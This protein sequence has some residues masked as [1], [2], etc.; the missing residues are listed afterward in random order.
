MRIKVEQ[1]VVSNDD[2]KVVA[3]KK[4]KLFK[5]STALKSKEVSIR[6]IMITSFNFLFRFRNSLFPPLNY[7]TA[8]AVTFLLLTQLLRPT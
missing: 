1:T 8:G 4:R 6:G 2:L 3:A 7:R 5:T